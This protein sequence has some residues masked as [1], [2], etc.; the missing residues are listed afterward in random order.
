VLVFFYFLI[1]RPEGDF[2][3]KFDL[4]MTY[5]N[6]ENVGFDFIRN[7]KFLLLL[8]AVYAYFETQKQMKKS[9]SSS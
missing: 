5:L 2:K 7:F 6:G 4:G 9:P 3:L 8:A 1:F